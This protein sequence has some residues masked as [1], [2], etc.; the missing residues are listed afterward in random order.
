M[1]MCIKLA[2]SMCRAQKHAI[3][4]FQFNASNRESF[5]I[6]KKK[7]ERRSVLDDTPYSQTTHT[8][9]TNNDLDP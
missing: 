1:Y 9:T 7:Q 2:I 5:I 3:M 8:Q 4:P 6:E